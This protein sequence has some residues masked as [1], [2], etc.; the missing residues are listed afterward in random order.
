MFLKV[1]L[2]LGLLNINFYGIH[3]MTA[4]QKAMIHAHFEK[5]GAECIKEHQ[6][7]VEDIKNLRAKKLPTG[8]NAPCF[9]SCVL[10]KIGVMDDKG[11]LQKESAMELAKKVFNDDEELKMVEDYLHSCSHINGESVSDGEKGC[12]RAILAYK[13]MSDNASQFGLEM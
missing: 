7:S 3:A 6:I 2:T 5:I 8:E 12:E 13:C 4:D 11:M 1:L 9:L 10:K